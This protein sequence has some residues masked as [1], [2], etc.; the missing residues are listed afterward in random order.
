MENKISKICWN[1]KGWKFP[2][3]SQ[4]KS[5][6]S[7]S[8]EAK[9][10]YGHEEWLFDKAR[11]IKGYH[12]AFLQPLNLKSGKHVG[13]TYN[14]DLFTI[15]GG[16]KYFVG[17][18]KNA[19]CISK[20]K[21]RDIYEIYKQKGWLKEMVKEIE[22]AG[23][24]PKTFPET[25]PDNFFN[26]K[27]KFEDVTRPEEIEELE[28]LS[29]QNTNITTP[30]YKLLPKSN[31]FK[32]VAEISDDENEGKYKNTKRRN[33]TYKVDSSL[34]PYHD[35]LQNALYT[36]LRDNYKNEYK[37]VSIEKG[38]VDIKAKTHSDRW[39]YFEIKT[40]CPKL[41]IRNAFGQILEYSYWP[42]SERAEKLIIISDNA[43]DSDTKKYLAHIRRKFN[44]P[45]FY[46][47][48][49]MDSNVLSEDF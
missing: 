16:T 20:A 21:S 13:N 25:S 9:Y 36:L 7:N 35:K 8:F 15:T 47:S 5:F 24:N 26:I 42:E 11:I 38:R 41:S 31:D 18:I 12:Y 10:G 14:I 1:S 32:F 34:D 30:R 49:N 22:M 2:S 27:F 39:H 3:G 48:F 19:A 37:N 28:E 43:P 29:G 44:L 17:Q 23:A 46:R 33:R 45:V 6:S 4:G 40:D